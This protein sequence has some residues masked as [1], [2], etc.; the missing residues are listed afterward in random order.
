MHANRR[1][2]WSLDLWKGK[3][4][5]IFFFDDGDVRKYSALHWTLFM[6]QP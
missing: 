2:E 1:A 3:A 6:S 4:E 5:I